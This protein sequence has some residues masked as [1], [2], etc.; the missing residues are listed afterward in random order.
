MPI[1]AIP[2]KAGKAVAS[3]PTARS[4]RR[5]VK[6]S[7]SFSVIIPV[8]P[9]LG[10]PSSLEPFRRLYSYRPDI[11]IIVVEGENPSA[12]RNLGARMASSDILVFLD[13]DSI[14]SEN[15][16][17][18]LERHYIDPEVVGVGGPNLASGGCGDVAF[19]IDKILC[20]RTGTSGIRA[21]F[22]SVGAVRPMTEDAVILCNFS[23]RRDFFLKTGGFDTR[24]FPNEE[25]EYLGRIKC[26]HGVKQILYDPNLVVYRQ[27]PTTILKH[28]SKIAG[29][30]EGR[31]RQT[32]IAP[33][34][35][36][37]MRLVPAIF[38]L[39]LLFLPVLTVAS[40]ALLLPLVFYLAACAIWSICSSICARSAPKIP[41]ALILLVMTHVSYGMGTVCGLARSACGLEAKRGSLRPHVRWEKR[42]DGEHRRKTFTS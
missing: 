35:T 7:L 11:E 42:L 20:S 19:W 4:R 22:S 26:L 16:L 1:S 8:P 29:Y 36:P 31:A 30:G 18:I 2:R 6:G 12:Q 32:V 10:Q 5:L 23:V 41:L 34:R 27:R 3:C 17:E 25:N 9:G 28:L 39:Y 38:V 24:L 40:S 21:K 13:D 37:L 14:I 15:Y 33:L